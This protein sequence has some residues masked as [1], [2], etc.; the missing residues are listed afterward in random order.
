[1]KRPFTVLEI[2]Y[3]D[4]MHL[5]HSGT[6]EVLEEKLGIG[7]IS[8]FHYDA[9]RHYKP[10]DLAQRLEKDFG[11]SRAETAALGKALDRHKG[12]IAIIPGEVAPPNPEGSL[13][14]L[15]V[16]RAKK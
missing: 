11:V 15:A 5:A 3:G 8:D 13:R 2:G 14:Q 4:F 6:P 9:L 1:M 16:F 12:H 7:P 10:G